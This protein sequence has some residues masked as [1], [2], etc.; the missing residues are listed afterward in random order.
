MAL[1][2]GLEH[3]DLDRTEASTAREDESGDH[4]QSLVMGRIGRL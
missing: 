4:D 1:S 2:E 3:A